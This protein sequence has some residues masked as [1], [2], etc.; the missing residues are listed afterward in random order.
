MAGDIRVLVRRGAD[1]VEWFDDVAR[2]RAE[3]FRAFP[4]L[5][6]GDAEY[7]KH[8][9]ATYA[10]SAGSV[11][12]VGASTGL[13]LGEAE[14]AFQAPFLDRGIPV[15]EVFYC[16]ESVLLPAFRGQGLGHRF[17]DERE[18]HAR[19]LGGI[20]WTSFASVNR[21]SDDPRRPAHYRGNDVVWTRRGYTRQPDMQV[22]LPWKQL[23]EAH[24]SEQTLTM[25]LRPLEGEQ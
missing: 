19:S 14:P 21:A 16:G 17:F 1:M 8:Y 5:Y 13:P 2:L 10:R 7:E 11:L 9:L 3:V 18:A 24:E 6:E 4:Y 12:V 23:G 22:S 15:E 25:W 20:R